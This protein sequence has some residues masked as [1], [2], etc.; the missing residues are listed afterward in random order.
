MCFLLGTCNEAGVYNGDHLRFARE[1]HVAEAKIC[2]RSLSTEVVA[3]RRRNNFVYRFDTIQGLHEP[4][5]LRSD[6]HRNH[7]AIDADVVLRY[8]DLLCYIG[9]GPLEVTIGSLMKLYLDCQRNRGL[10]YI[11]SAQGVF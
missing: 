5:L 2:M 11:K 6:I 4:Q 9:S 1:F 10:L 3:Q 7:A 8:S